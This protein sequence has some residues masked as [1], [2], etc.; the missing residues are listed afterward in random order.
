[1]VLW[2]LRL[3]Q[4]W[5]SV[6]F[7]NWVMILQFDLGE[8]LEVDLDSFKVTADIMWLC[9]A[10]GITRV[11][12]LKNSSKLPLL[13]QIK[14]LIKSNKPQKGTTHQRLPRY[15]DTLVPLRVRGKVLLV[16]NCQLFLNLAL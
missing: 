15:P 14:A 3:Q 9:N 16:Q 1:M 11:W 5:Q 7:T 2:F 6:S 4:Q 13:Q 12:W 8:N 10:C